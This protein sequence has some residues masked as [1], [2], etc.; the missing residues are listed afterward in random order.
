M[1]VAGGNKKVRTI[2]YLQDDLTV[3]LH[4]MYVSVCVPRPRLGH[5][6]LSMHVCR[7]CPEAR[8]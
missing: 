4:C 8:E 3:I 6:I 1:L 5:L 7:R 2:L